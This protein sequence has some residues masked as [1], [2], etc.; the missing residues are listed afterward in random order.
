M[1]DVARG[2]GFRKAGQRGKIESG[3]AFLLRQNMRHDCVR[4]PMPQSML[5]LEHR[6]QFHVLCWQFAL[7]DLLPIPD[8]PSVLLFYGWEV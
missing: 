2:I 8:R 7:H 6:H 5:G 3:L 1:A 4:V